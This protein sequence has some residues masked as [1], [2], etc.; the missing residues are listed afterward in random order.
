MDV[1]TLVHRPD[2]AR[3]QS[4]QNL[5]LGSVIAWH[6]GV[7]EEGLVSAG[8]YILLLRGTENKEAQ[9]IADYD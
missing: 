1:C 6:W 9:S 8:F 4:F 7:Y 5:L 2:S 3:D